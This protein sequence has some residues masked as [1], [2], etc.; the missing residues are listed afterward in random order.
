MVKPDAMW[1]SQILDN[2]EELVVFSDGDQN[3][4]WM[5]RVAKLFAEKTRL[6]DE[7]NLCY[8]TFFGYEAPCPNCPVPLAKATKR[9]QRAEI[10]APDGNWW[11]VVSTPLNLALPSGEVCNGFLNVSRIKAQDAPAGELSSTSEVFYKAV[12]E[13]QTEFIC[14]FTPE[15]RLTFTNSAICR[16]FS[17]DQANAIGRHLEDFLTTDELRRFMIRLER[18]TPRHPIQTFR[19]HSV[20]PQGRDYWG[21]WTIRALYNSEGFLVE[22]QAVGRDVTAEQL[23]RIQLAESQANLEDAQA[24][25]HIGSWRWDLATNEVIWSDEVWRIFGLPPR[26]GPLQRGA[27]R[28]MVHPEDLPHLRAA[29]RETLE[30]DAP[31][32]LH[33]RIFRTDQTMRIIHARGVVRR[34]ATGKPIRFSGMLHDITERQ[35]TQS[36]LEK[37]ESRLKAIVTSIPDLMFRLDAEGR[38]LECYAE[39]E[40]LLVAEPNKLLG[41]TLRDVLPAEVS[42][43]AYAVLN[44]TLASDQ[45][46][47][48]EYQLDLPAGT[49]WFEARMTKCD[50]H[51][52]LAIVRNITSHAQTTQALQESEERYRFLFDQLLD[53]VYIHRRPTTPG[54]RLQLLEA[55]IAASKMLGYSLEEFQTLEIEDVDTGLPEVNTQID[56]LMNGSAPVVFESMHRAKSGELIPVEIH[57]RSMLLH[58]EEIVVSVIRDLRAR[59]RM[60][61]ELRDRE[62]R[63][64]QMYE[65]HTLPM[66]LIDPPTGQILGANASALHFYGYSEEQFLRLNIADINALRTAEVAQAQESAANETCSRFMFPHRLA[67][68]ELRTVEVN[69]SP[70][71]VDGQI[72]LFSIINDVTDREQ[73]LALLAASEARF[74]S[75]LNIAPAGIGVVVDRVILWTNECM[76]RLLGYS[77]DELAGKGARM[78]YPSQQE[79]EQVGRDK[80]LLINATGKGSV[81]TKW[82]CR[83]GKLLDILLSSIPFDPA[84][85]SK[86]VLFT[87]LDITERKIVEAERDRLINELS[88]SLLEIR[89][90][91]ELLG[92]T[93]HLTKLGGWEWDAV[94]QKMVWTDEVYRIHGLAPGAI[95]TGAPEHIQASLRCYAPKDRPVIDAAFERCAAEGIPYDLEFPLTTYDGRRIWINTVAQPKLLDGKIIGVLG[96]IRDITEQKLVADALRISEERIASA[97]ANAPIGMGFFSPAGQWLKG[98]PAIQSI[99]GY[100]EAELQT[101]T[102]QDLIHP[103]D[104]QF[105]MNNVRQLL[106]GECSSLHLEERYITKT[107][108]IVWGHLSVSLIRDTA[109]Q[110]L[111]FIAQIA[112]ITER[113]QAE[114]ERDQL[115]SD[116]QKSLKE[117]RQLSGLLPICANCKKIRNDAGYWQQIE[118]FIEQRSAAQFSH[119]ICP[120]CL[121]KL[122]PDYEERTEQIE[123][124]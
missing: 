105:S 50:E 96:H 11:E 40:E 26:P 93:Q 99:F 65:H 9:S 66:I 114:L 86:G 68:G 53:P 98:N 7:E 8:K 24:I 78:L 113:K 46:C 42:E 2:M 63:F 20:T 109:G 71:D 59:H 79:F 39:R 51:E 48:L 91:H 85:L 49:F 111:H 77:A 118:R 43:R 12:V 4:L 73:T 70:I 74:R 83:D 115:I 56:A 23:A 120:T 52:V 100:T 47:C 72:V 22:Y 110:P 116:L 81:E 31:Y 122:Y 33:Y 82:I 19:V 101:M 58:H 94:M 18:I 124:P 80:Y 36:A 123:E 107:G 14:R 1:L 102:F 13:D 103:D 88:N 5:N 38:Y 28:H 75:L 108:Q 112:D 62:Q 76:Q 61:K 87:A 97:F 106:D 16:L 117:I 3:I 84:D 67:S 15:G 54:E 64:R 6:N 89:K 57:A 32:D 21:D 17:I 92:Q 34:D 29:M 10:Q 25:A 90:S 60:E 119:S 41:S 95:A 30:N 121:K 27:F 45:P 55:N 37:S 69:S 104:Q 35:A 44:Q